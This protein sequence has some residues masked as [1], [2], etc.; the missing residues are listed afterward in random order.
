MNIS[1]VKANPLAQEVRCTEDELIVELIDGRRISVPLS[2]FPRLSNASPEQLNN[3]EIL[4]N[5]EGIHWPEI[6]EDLCVEGLLMGLNL[7]MEKSEA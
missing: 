6:D 1:T 5:G 7:P 3:W 4:G 2:W